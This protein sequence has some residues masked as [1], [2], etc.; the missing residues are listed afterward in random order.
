MEKITSSSSG[1]R[2]CSIWSNLDAAAAAAI[3]RLVLVKMLLNFSS[4]F[5][6]LSLSVF[7]VLF[8]LLSWSSISLSFSLSLPLSLPLFI[9]LYIYLSPS[10]ITSSLK[11]GQRGKKRL[12][13]TPLTLFY[14]VFSFFSF[15][16]QFPPLF[17]IS[18]SLSPYFLL[19]F[20]LFHFL[21]SL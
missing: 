8:L 21:I 6:S 2:I 17:D 12:I 14:I 15:L 7:S 1:W 9:S 19:F 20:S 3:F 18:L 4:P 13:F 16:F 10:Q 11:K 5:F